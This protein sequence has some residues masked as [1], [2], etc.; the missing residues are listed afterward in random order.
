MRCYNFFSAGGCKNIEDDKDCQKWALKGEC[1]T[2]KT[3]MHKNCKKSC[4]LCVAADEPEE[5]DDNETENKPRNRDDDD[6]DNGRERLHKTFFF[7]TYKRFFFQKKVGELYI[8]QVH[9]K[10]FNLKKKTSM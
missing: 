1:I 9:G 4:Q 3:W 8:N 5:G 2:K 7:S 6:E 10:S